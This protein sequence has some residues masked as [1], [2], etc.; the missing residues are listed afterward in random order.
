MPRVALTDRFVST[1]KSSGGQTDYFDEKVPGLALRAT[2]AGRKTWTLVFTSP[3]TTKR[4]RMTLGGYPQTS[5]AQA[6]ALGLE[7][8]GQLDEGRDPRDVRAEQQ[9]AALRFSGLVEGYLER[10]ARPSLRSAAEIE[11]RL[12]KN[13]LPLIGN[14]KISEISRRDVSRAIDPVLKRGCRVEAGRV[15]EDL[16]AVL[17]WAVARGDLERNPAEGMIKPNGGAPRERVLS[18]DEIG[19]L[20]GA[21]P[22]VLAKSQACQRIIK[23]CLLT[24]QRVGEVAGLPICELDI[25]AAAWTIPGAR[26]KNGHRHVVPLSVPAIAIIKDAIK[27][28]DMSGFLF[29]AK[30]ARR[31]LDSAAVGRTIGRAQDRFGV[32]HWTAHD[33]RRTSVSGMAQMGVP[34]IVL[35]HITNHRSVTKAGVTLSVYTHY[36]YADEKRE[37]LGRWAKRLNEIVGDQI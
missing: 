28:A 23:L 25:D 32:P 21:L 29:P 19:V 18:D 34:P 2:A 9:A 30:D 24:A 1:I 10:H 35:G 7:A 12:S 33:L 16:R 4:T 27:D 26:T 11:R 20:W 22:A 37:A 15:F 5:L 8:R 36:D 3:R 17:S 31:A 14:L 6:R 13:V